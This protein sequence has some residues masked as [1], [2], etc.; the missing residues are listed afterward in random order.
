MS[1]PTHV[2]VALKKYVVHDICKQEPHGDPW[3]NLLLASSSPVF[4]T[5]WGSPAAGS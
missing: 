1:E 4:L 5:P 3:A 2:S